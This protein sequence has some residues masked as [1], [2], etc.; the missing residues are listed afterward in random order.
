MFQGI[1]VKTALTFAN[2]RPSMGQV[3]F[4]RTAAAFSLPALPCMDETW[5]KAE[6]AHRHVLGLED[7]V[8]PGEGGVVA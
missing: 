7:P 8:P 1:F 4:V 6:Y 3:A 5:S 2:R